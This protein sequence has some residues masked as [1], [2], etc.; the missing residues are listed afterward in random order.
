MV[1]RWAPDGKH[2]VFVDL[3]TGPSSS[4][5][6]GILLVSADGGNPEAVN[7]GPRRAYDPSWS[8]DGKLLAFGYKALPPEPASIHIYNLETHSVS[9]VA[10]S[11]GIY[12]PRWSPDGRYIAGLSSGGQ[13][14]MLFDFQTQSWAPLASDGFGW[15]MWSHDSRYVY[16]DN[17]KTG[18]WGV[19]RVRVADGKVERFL[20]LKGIDAPPSWEENYVGLAPDDSV[21]VLKNVVSREIYALDWEAP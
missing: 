7:P 13:N 8:P 2:I 6:S 10:G 21:F 19:F 3:G 14:L 16:F 15:H 12:S 17:A 11:D 5:S 9:K 4:Q 1:P 18:D 20:S